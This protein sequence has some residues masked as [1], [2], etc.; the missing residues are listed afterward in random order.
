MLLPPKHPIICLCFLTIGLTLEVFLI[1]L[2]TYIPEP[3][4]T[5]LFKLHILTFILIFPLAA[6]L[7]PI[8]G[9]LAILIG[10]EP[11]FTVNFYLNMNA[12]SC[13]VNAFLS[14][15]TLILCTILKIEFNTSLTDLFMIL[16]IILLKIINARFGGAYQAYLENKNFYSN[17][18]KLQ[19]KSI[20]S[21]QYHEQKRDDDESTILM[22]EVT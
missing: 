21:P 18:L 8:I 14:L 3:N 17:Q 7:T 10:K 9:I 16:G 22:K 13:V 4:D 19:F 15:L 20:G 12:A 11:I 5:T 2:L 6:Y 1:F